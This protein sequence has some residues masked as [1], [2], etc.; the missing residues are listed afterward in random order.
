MSED[1]CDPEASASL[2]PKL[3]EANR[4]RHPVP[5][6]FKTEMK[7]YLKLGDGSDVHLSS[8]RN[9]EDRHGD[10]HL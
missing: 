3:T 9:T 7:L 4:D 5:L 6:S 2:K 1:P 10:S 8:M